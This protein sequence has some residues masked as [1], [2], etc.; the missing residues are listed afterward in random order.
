MRAIL[1]KDVE[2]KVMKKKFFTLIELLVVIAIIAILAAMLLP[3]L[4][5]ARGRAKAIG[6]SN[7][8]KQLAIGVQMYVMENNDCLFQTFVTAPD[9]GWV[10]YWHYKVHELLGKGS[11]WGELPANYNTIYWCVEDNTVKAPSRDAQSS[12]A[13]NYISYGFNIYNL[14]GM[15]VT[16]I[17]N[18]SE[19]IC[20]AE[21]GVGGGSTGYV[22]CASYFDTDSSVWPA[23]PRHNGSCNIMWNDGHV[24][25]VH[26]PNKL[27]NG[28]YNDSVLGARGWWNPVDGGSVGN[29]WIPY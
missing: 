14:R 11:A 25:A 27:S 8:L 5:G 24:S 10:V 28:L 18:P 17:K 21:S 9:D 26:S 20:I 23:T 1:N 7:N 16:R 3:A 15:K 22:A 6:C 12:F 29:K 4:N 13:F 19:R 2:G